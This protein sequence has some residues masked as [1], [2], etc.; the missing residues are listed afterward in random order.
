MPLDSIGK[1]IGTVGV[2][3]GVAAIVYFAPEC[4]EVG[5]CA[6]FGMLATLFI[7]RD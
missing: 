5:I 6:F 2:W 7:W 4:G 1:A 3:G